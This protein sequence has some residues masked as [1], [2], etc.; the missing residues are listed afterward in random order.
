MTIIEKITEDGVL[1]SAVT[2]KRKRNNSSMS[3]ERTIINETLDCKLSIKILVLTHWLLTVNWI[4]S[5]DSQTG[6]H[7]AQKVTAENQTI[8]SSAR[9][10]TK[11]NQTLLNNVTQ[12]QRQEK[13]KKIRERSKKSLQRQNKLHK[14]QQEKVTRQNFK[15][16]QWSHLKLQRCF[17]FKPTL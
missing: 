17:K 10:I 1:V 8:S 15:A 6:K 7:K 14:I 12:S 9:R 16:V 13:L 3:I 5:S 4:Y 2:L 11:S